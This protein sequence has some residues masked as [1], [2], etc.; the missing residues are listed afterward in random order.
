MPFR[1]NSEAKIRND[2]ETP[3]SARGTAQTKRKKR[4]GMSRK[5]ST[6]ACSKP[7]PRRAKT[8]RVATANAGPWNLSSLTL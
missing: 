2:H 5:S 7:K 1:S 6:A 4:D 8:A 3:G